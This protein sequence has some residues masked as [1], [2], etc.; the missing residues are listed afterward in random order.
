MILLTMFGALIIAAAA[1]LFLIH[2]VGKFRFIAKLS[3]GKRAVKRAVSAAVV[4]LPLV[5]IGILWGLT[6]A[7]IVMLHL[8]IFWALSELIMYIVRRVGKRDFRR[9]YAGAAAILITV[10]YLTVGWVQA[11]RVWRTDYAVSTDKKV[12]TLRVA[13]LADSH[14]GTTF[15]GKGLAEHIT[16]INRQKPD[17]VV[18]AG[19][20]VDESTSK[21]DMRD[22][23]RALKNLNAPYGTYFVFGNHD[24]GKY[25]NGSRGYDGDDLVKEL[26]KNGVAVLQ[27][28]NV[29]IDDR[30]YIIGRQDASEELD[31]GG[32]RAKIGDLTRGLDNDKFSIVLDHQPHDY[33]AEAAAG[34]DL[35]LSGHTHG[36]QMIP[37][38][39]LIGW[40]HLGGDDN[41]YGAERRKN[42]DFFV[43]SGISDW[44][45]K[46][47]TGCRSEY[48]IIDIKGK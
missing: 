47:K 48:V 35:V 45:I 30:F 42:T 7:V 23:C 13:L 19:D 36:G 28:E 26:E 37:L 24:K 32:S 2:N 41:V 15:D 8:A 20:F 17:V 5:L 31:F 4:L 34:V 9:Y 11:H 3:H 16:E 6:N 12:G 22:A 38:V 44:A 39:Q 14:I 43:T 21:T 27:D 46:F 25:S 10:V 29:L 33:T 1:I 18:I 40:F